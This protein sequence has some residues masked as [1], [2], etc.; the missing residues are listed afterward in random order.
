MRRVLISILI[1]CT[2]QLN[3]YSLPLIWDFPRLTISSTDTVLIIENMTWQYHCLPSRGSGTQNSGTQQ[4]Q[5]LWGQR[6]RTDQKEF[7]RFVWV[8]LSFS[9]RYCTCL[10]KWACFEP[11]AIAI[12]LHIK[13]SSGGIHNGV[14]CHWSTPMAWNSAHCGHCSMLQTNCPSTWKN[15]RKT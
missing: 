10:G 5:I 1:L 2:C 12:A 14:V 6:Q 8:P 11:F 7:Q 4:A 9:S 15:F 13:S 3:I